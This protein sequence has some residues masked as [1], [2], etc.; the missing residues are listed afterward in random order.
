M[1][2]KKYHTVGTIPK[3]NIKIVDSCKIDILP[4]KHMLAHFHGLV[5]KLQ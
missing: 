5:Q 3:A 1:T 2:N 4:H